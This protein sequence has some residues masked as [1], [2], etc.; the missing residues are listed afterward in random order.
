MSASQNP[1]VTNALDQIR[2]DF[3]FCRAQSRPRH[4][5]M[6]MTNLMPIKILLDEIDRLN[7]QCAALDWVKTNV[8]NIDFDVIVPAGVM[9]TNP[10]IAVGDNFESAIAQAKQMLES[11][12]AEHSEGKG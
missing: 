9:S 3:E 8:G 2:K 1:A 11:A 7:G 6:M 5:A 4:E 12:R 10:W